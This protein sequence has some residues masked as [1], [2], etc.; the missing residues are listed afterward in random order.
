MIEIGSCFH[1]FLMD[2]FDTKAGHIVQSPLSKASLRISNLH[3]GWASRGNLI[4]LLVA[5]L[6]SL[7][8]ILLR[9]REMG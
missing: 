9:S 4:S 1:Y 5:A 8:M 7:L 3:G 2:Q 6:T